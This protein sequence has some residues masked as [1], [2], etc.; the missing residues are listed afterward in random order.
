M[1]WARHERVNTLK[2]H[3]SDVYERPGL[4][5]SSTRRPPTASTRATNTPDS[6][7]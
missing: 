4:A 5:P 1:N 3:A 6:W 2:K 7:A